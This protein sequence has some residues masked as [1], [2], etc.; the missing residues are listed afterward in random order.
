MLILAATGK[1]SGIICFVSFVISLSFFIKSLEEFCHCY[2][3]PQPKSEAF[4]KTIIDFISH[5]I[6]FTICASKLILTYFKLSLI[7]SVLLTIIIACALSYC[8]FKFFLKEIPDLTT[9]QAR[10][11]LNPTASLNVG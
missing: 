5:N 3:G 6:V 10:W 8:F 9:R 11:V 7:M 1:L 2:S 4:V